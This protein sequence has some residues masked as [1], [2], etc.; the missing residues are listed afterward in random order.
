[1]STDIIKFPSSHLG[2][3]GGE[4]SSAAMRLYLSISV[5]FMVLTFLGSWIF[6]RWVRHQDKLS[7]EQSDEQRINEKV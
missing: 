7:L 1:M 5:P 4:Y 2:A 3:F 6:Y